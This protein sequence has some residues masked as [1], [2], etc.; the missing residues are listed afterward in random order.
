MAYAT[1]PLIL[2]ASPDQ[3]TTTQLQGQRYCKCVQRSQFEKRPPFLP[4]YT[5]TQRDDNEKGR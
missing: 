5:Y 1:L 3:V 4:L 2:G